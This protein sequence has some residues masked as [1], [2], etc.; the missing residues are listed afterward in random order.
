MTYLVNVTITKL[1][2]SDFSNVHVSHPCT[3]HYRSNDEG[4]ARTF[5]FLD[6]ICAFSSLDNPYSNIM[7]PACIIVLPLLRY[8][9]PFFLVSIRPPVF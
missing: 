5:R 4:T 7:F 2:R 1:F 3:L 9:L 6:V 8:L